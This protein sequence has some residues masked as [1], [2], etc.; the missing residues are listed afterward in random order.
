MAIP[1]FIIAFALLAL[2]G[3][4][5]VYLFSMRSRPFP[6]AA[7]PPGVAG[8]SPE[9][10]LAGRLARG[11]IDVAEFNARIDALRTSH[12]ERPQ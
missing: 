6:G 5:I 2:V 7:R 9:D 12:R 1:H 4:A 8:S 3:A 11:E 10:V